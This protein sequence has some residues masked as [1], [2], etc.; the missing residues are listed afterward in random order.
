MFQCVPRRYGSHRET[1]D[2]T[3]PARSLQACGIRAFGVGAV[4]AFDNGDKDRL[5][6]PRA[7]LR[8]TGRHRH[9]SQS[10]AR[11]CS[12]A[13]L[14]W[15]EPC[16]RSRSCGRAVCVTGR[17]PP[18]MSLTPYRSARV[19]SKARYSV[20]RGARRSRKADRRKPCW[21]ELLPYF[22]HNCVSGSRYASHFAPMFRLLLVRGRCGI[23][24]VHQPLH[25]PA[26]GRA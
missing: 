19:R 5:R 26:D 6:V 1:A 15:S 16:P 17:F 4:A 18:R 14:R 13:T 3:M 25:N 23:S 11:S 24:L 12:S 8:N 9:S 10:V 2:G 22:R 7:G 20:G 21:C